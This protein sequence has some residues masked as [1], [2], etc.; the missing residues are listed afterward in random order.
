MAAQSSSLTSVPLVPIGPPVPVEVSG[1]APIFVRFGVYGWA[2]PIGPAAISVS[3]V[4]VTFVANAD[5]RSSM[6]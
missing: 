6:L 4:P 3:R 2:R 5:E 1:E